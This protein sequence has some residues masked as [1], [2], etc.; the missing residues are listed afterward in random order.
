MD[1]D[2]RK[3]RNAYQRE[4][5]ARNREKVRAINARYWNKKAQQSGDQRKDSG[6]EENAAG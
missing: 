1:D 6:A 2:A 5:R 4:W 3:A